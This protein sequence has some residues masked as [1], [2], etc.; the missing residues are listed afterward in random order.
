MISKIKEA[1]KNYNGEWFEKKKS[2]KLLRDHGKVAS[3]SN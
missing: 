3:R 2:I 1:L